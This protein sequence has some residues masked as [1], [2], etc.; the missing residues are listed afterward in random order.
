MG[1]NTRQ[2]NAQRQEDSW[3]GE[4]VHVAWA[5]KSDV[6]QTGLEIERDF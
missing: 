1:L 4:R 3:V 2:G 5:K 6:F